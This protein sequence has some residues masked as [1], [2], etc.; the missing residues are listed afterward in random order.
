MNAVRSIH[1]PFLGVLGQQ[2]RNGCISATVRVRRWVLCPIIRLT[3]ALSA[4]S[5]RIANELQSG[6]LYE[7]ERQLLPLPLVT[8]I[9]TRPR[10]FSGA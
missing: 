7:C 10:E 9:G 2:K 4:E 5:G 8:S 3:I 6:P 1:T